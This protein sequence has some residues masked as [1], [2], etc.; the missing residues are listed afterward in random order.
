MHT[1]TEENPV[2]DV[3][4]ERLYAYLCDMHSHGLVPET[5]WSLRLAFFHF[6]RGETLPKR[7]IESLRRL[8]QCILNQLHQN[9]VHAAGDRSDPEYHRHSVQQEPIGATAAA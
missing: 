6:I 9:T 3:Q 4:D 5:S 7:E 1:M 2:T 8:A